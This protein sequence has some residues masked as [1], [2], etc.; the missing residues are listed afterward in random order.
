MEKFTTCGLAEF[1]AHTRPTPLT[2]SVCYSKGFFEHPAKKRNPIARFVQR[3]NRIGKSDGE[4]ER[5]EDDIA[6]LGK[7]PTDFQHPHRRL[8]YTPVGNPLLPAETQWRPRSYSTSVRPRK[9]SN[10]I[11]T[12]FIFAENTAVHFRRLA[13]QNALNLRIGGSIHAD[14]IIK[15][16]NFEDAPM[17]RRRTKMNL[18]VTR[19][20][21]QVQHLG[22]HRESFRYRWQSNTVCTSQPSSL[23]IVQSGLR[24]KKRR[25]APQLVLMTAVWRESQIRSA[26]A[27]EWK[28]LQSRYLSVKGSDRDVLKPLINHQKRNWRETER[29]AS[30]VSSAIVC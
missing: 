5:R 24:L 1:F 23:P 12:T 19:P 4:K 21:C 18:P 20:G 17:Y 16:D 13:A 29:K 8:P 3:V 22:W 25:I 7:I 10:C 30:K 28:W 2:E 15:D 26:L 11:Y 9:D 14:I 6:L 27:V